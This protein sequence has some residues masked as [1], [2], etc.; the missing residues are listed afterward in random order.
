MIILSQFF[1]GGMH[2]L[3]ISYI[4][5][6]VTQLL[7]DHL[8]IRTYLSDP[9]ASQVMQWCRKNSPANAGD[10]GDMGLSPGSGRYSG[11]GNSSPLQ[12]SFLEN[13]MDRGA[14]RA[15][16]HGVAE[17]RTRLKR[18]HTHACSACGSHDFRVWWSLLKKFMKEAMWE[19]N[20]YEKYSASK[21]QH[22]LFFFFT[23]NLK[24]KD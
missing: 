16:V 23:E 12:Y 9:R 18:L 7:N 20:S 13:P 10:T 3:E 4:L 5:S 2:D 24:H 6:I 17:S 22:C 21:N 8:K 19:K 11:G 1:R 14:W 15:T